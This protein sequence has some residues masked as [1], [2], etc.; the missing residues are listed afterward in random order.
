MIP[1]INMLFSK[2]KTFCPP[3]YYCATAHLG[4]LIIFIVALCIDHR[5]LGGMNIWAKPLKFALSITVYCFTW[6]LILRY[7]PDNR[8]RNRFVSFTVFVLSF[9]MFAIASQAARGELSHFNQSGIY[10]IV[11]YALMGI[12]I[13]AQTF[14]SLYIGRL[15]FKIKALRL[16]PAMLWAIRI[17]IVTAGIFALQGALM[18]Q[19]MSHSV[20]MASGSGMPVTGWSTTAGDLRIAHF[21]GLHALQVVPLF[22]LIT[23]AKHRL[24]IIFGIAYFAFATFLFYR[25]LLGLPLG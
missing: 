5:M 14:F 19:R 8:I 4:L 24:V 11:L 2:I 15:F 20:G 6:P 7:L 1:A 10:N 16:S 18:G 25:A 9:E 21:L 22:A 17:G 23:K 13:T 12:F 3:L